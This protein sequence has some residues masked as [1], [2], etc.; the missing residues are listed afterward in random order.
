MKH[1]E[2]SNEAMRQAEANPGTDTE[3]GG[4]ADTDKEQTDRAEDEDGNDVRC[5]FKLK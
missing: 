1:L 3:A 2:D 5:S 4:T